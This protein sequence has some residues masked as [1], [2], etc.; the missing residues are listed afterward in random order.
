[1]AVIHVLIASMRWVFFKG[2]VCILVVFS[3]MFCVSSDFIL[4]PDGV[5]GLPGLL[6]SVV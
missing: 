2:I 3:I 4:Q 6:Q 5:E 1:M